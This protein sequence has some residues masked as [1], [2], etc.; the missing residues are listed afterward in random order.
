MTSSAQ[1]LDLKKIM[2]MF[3]LA[4]A[5]FAGLAAYNPAG[6]NAAPA[7]AVQISQAQQL[8]GP[9][10]EAAPISAQASFYC[11]YYWNSNRV[12][13]YCNVYSGY[14]RWWGTCSNGGT[15]YTPWATGWNPNYLYLHYWVQCGS[16]NLTSFGYQTVG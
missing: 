7:P 14:M 3:V 11:E 8:V 4:I 16:Y 12:D 15:Y 2:R 10:V 6:A 13:A 9:V 5:V 1:A